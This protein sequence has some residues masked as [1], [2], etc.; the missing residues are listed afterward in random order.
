MRELVDDADKLVVE[1]SQRERWPTTEAAEPSEVVDPLMRERLDPVLG[2]KLRHEV[3]V[4]HGGNPAGAVAVCWRLQRGRA[5]DR[6]PLARKPA[7]RNKL[8]LG[9]AF[10][11]PSGRL[12]EAAAD[13]SVAR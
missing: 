4:S 3:G 11:R 13:L 12:E 6:S 5:E 10:W 8:T 1:A 9:H 2:F 7:K